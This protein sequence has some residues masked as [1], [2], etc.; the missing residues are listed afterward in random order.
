MIG[1][2][3][4]IRLWPI[5]VLI[6]AREQFNLFKIVAYQSIIKIYLFNIYKLYKLWKCIIFYALKISGS[7][8]CI[9][10]FKCIMALKN[11]SA[12]LAK[13]QLKLPKMNHILCNF[14]ILQLIVYKFILNLYE[15][16]LF[17]WRWLIK[18]IF[19]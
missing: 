17:I 14:S 6:G 9:K 18:I 10:V 7:K 2:S 8:K 11:I 16:S 13:N 4:I 1:Q 3:V 5:G 15:N 19:R 12:F